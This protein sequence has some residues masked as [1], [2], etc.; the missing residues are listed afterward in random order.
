M[1]GQGFYKGSAILIGMVVVTKVIGLVFKL[2][3]TNLLGGVGM[4][5][6]SGVYAVF[7]PVFAAAVG[8]ISSA[9]AIMTAES[10]ALE[11]YKNVRKIKNTSLLV[12]T[13]SG[14]VL[15]GALVVLSPFISKAVSGGESLRPGLMAAAPAVLLCSVLSCL[16]GYSEGFSDMVPTAVS[17]I[18]ETV[19]KLFLGVGL[20]LLISKTLPAG[21]DKN[22]GFSRICAA[23][24]LGV[25]LSSFFADVYMF[26]HF[27]LKGDGIDKTRLQRDKCTDSFKHIT[28]ELLHYST[29]IALTAAIST[30]INTADLLTVPMMLRRLIA[31]GE[32]DISPLVMAGVSVDDIPQ[33][34]YGSFT[35]MAL[36]ITGMIPGF[37]AMPCKPA[38]PGVS[39]ARASGDKAALEKSINE[40]MLLSMLIA[41]PASMGLMLFSRESLVFLFPSRQAEISVSAM[42]LA[43]LSAGLVF[44]CLLPPVFALLQAVGKPGTPVRIIGLSCVIKLFLNV[45]LMSVPVLNI[46]GAALALVLS[47]MAAFIIGER[48]LYKATGIRPDAVKVYISPVFAGALCA[49]SARLSYDMMFFKAGVRAGLL[50]AVVVGGIIY[51]F[52][53]YLLNILP[54][55]VLVRKKFKKIAKRT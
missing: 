45:M 1:K 47:D 31:D 27:R 14:A 29:P 38:L 15:G 51:I 43:V 9:V 2:I 35:A 8:G 46:N 36:S 16:R 4:A 22:E 11:R 25:S 33:F 13:L 23:A 53:L 34:V 37:T 50:S 12:F 7:T 3:I 42:P 30:L 18:I 54:K 41:C 55:N 40:V 39:R 49:V 32:Y 48:C 21:V 10:C 52:S 5:Y 26:I 19:F 44:G 6:F 17:E 28:I 20:A 24:V